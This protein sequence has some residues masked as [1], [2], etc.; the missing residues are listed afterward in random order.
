MWNVR[1]IDFVCPSELCSK[2]KEYFQ[3]DG[4]VTD[5]IEI[6]QDHSSLFR[7]LAFFEEDLERRCKMHKRRVDMLEPICNGTGLLPLTSLGSSF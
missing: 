7:A 5:H 2:A 3:M 6:L 4:Y 1:L